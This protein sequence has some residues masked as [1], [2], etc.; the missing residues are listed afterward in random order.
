MIEVRYFN[1]KNLDEVLMDKYV[2]ELPDFMLQE[3]NRY[4]IENDR[5]T[6]LIARLTI[7]EYLV[8]P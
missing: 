5:K 8:V 1:I 3:I 2:E 6:R 4:K 7:K